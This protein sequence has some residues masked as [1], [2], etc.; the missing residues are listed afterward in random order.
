MESK[1]SVRDALDAVNRDA[2]QRYADWKARNQ[3]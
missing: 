2:N 3:K 1:R